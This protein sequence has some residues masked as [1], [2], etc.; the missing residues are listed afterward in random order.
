MPAAYPTGE[1]ARAAAVITDFFVEREETDAV[2]LTNSCARGRATVDSC[3]DMQVIAGP[4]AVERLESEFES[5]ASSSAAVARLLGVGRFSELHLDV[6]DGVL[7]PG[8]IDEEG[9]DMFEVAVGNVFV[10]PVPMYVRG[11]RYERLRAD[12]LPFYDDQLRS[13]RLDAARW[14]VHDVNLARIGWLVGRGLHFQ[15]FDRFYRAFQGFLLGLHLA[16]RT[17]PIAYNKWIREQVVDNLD[18]PELYAELPPLFEIEEFESRALET[19]AH[20][21]RSLAEEYLCG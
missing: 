2:L 18:L 11:D 10:Y 20:R 16:R 17:Y 12:W 13:E 8:R 9:L 7:T 19:K 21:L 15:A 5:F 14:F 6:I 3:L 1:H 4:A